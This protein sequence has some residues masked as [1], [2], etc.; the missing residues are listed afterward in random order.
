MPSAVERWIEEWESQDRR[1]PADDENCTYCIST[2]NFIVSAYGRSFS[3]SLLDQVSEFSTINH[4]VIIRVELLDSCW[5]SEEIETQLHGDG[6]FII[7][8]KAMSREHAGELL[9]RGIEQIALT[10][11]AELMD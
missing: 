2:N 5:H 1:L 6:H 4:P 7:S 8:I 10:T 9:K 3:E 11:K